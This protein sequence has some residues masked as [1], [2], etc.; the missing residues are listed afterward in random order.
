[1]PRKTAST[2]GKRELVAIQPGDVVR[3]HGYDVQ[4]YAYKQMHAPHKPGNKARTVVA[5]LH[6]YQKSG[7]AS[8][9]ALGGHLWTG[10]LV[11]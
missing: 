3:I 5:E 2:G 8:R 6:C 10:T 4:Y 7:N 1:M 9:G 11:L